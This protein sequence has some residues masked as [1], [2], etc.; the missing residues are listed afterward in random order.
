KAASIPGIVTAG[1]P[2][3]AVRCPDHPVALELIRTFGKPL[4]GPSANPSGRISPTA[5]AHVQ[6]YFAPQ[7][8][9]VLEGGACRAGIEST[10]V[11]IVDPLRPIILRPGVIAAAQLEQVLKVPV[12]SETS[13]PRDGGGG[14]L[15]GPGMLPVHYA[16]VTPAM[17]AS[18]PEVAQMA[19]KATPRLA[20]LAIAQPPVIARG[21]ELIKMGTDAP[22]YARNLYAALMRADAAHCDLIVV[23]RPP[24]QDGDPLWVAVLDRLNRA[25]SPKVG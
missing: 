24:M 6:S 19:A 13:S 22:T 7:Q 25:T 15:A 2:N 4:V 1:S 20:I 18:A 14:P 9:M 12:A 16:P 11:S 8:V 23:E 17:L 3:V 5:A 10:V 21:H